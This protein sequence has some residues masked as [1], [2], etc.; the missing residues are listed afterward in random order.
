MLVFFSFLAI[1]A[2]M[3]VPTFNPHF[4]HESSLVPSWTL[5]KHATVGPM[6]SGTVDEK[7]SN[8]N[9]KRELSSL[10]VNVLRVVDWCNLIHS[11]V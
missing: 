11:N 5:R 6:I 8:K 2:E 9:K 4:S 7:R 3:T 10:G 1:D